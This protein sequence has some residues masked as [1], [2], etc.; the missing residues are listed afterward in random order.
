MPIF[1][2]VCQV[3]YRGMLWAAFPIPAPKGAGELGGGSDFNDLRSYVGASLP[4]T[5]SC[6]AYF[7]TQSELS[8]TCYQLY[9]TDPAV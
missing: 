7:H 4:M 5:V 8:M 2:L 1:S 6:W 9:S 3:Y